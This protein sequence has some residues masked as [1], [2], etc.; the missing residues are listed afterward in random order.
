MIQIAAATSRWPATTS[1]PAPCTASR[2]T[3]ETDEKD[4]RQW[5]DDHNVPAFLRLGDGH[6]LAVYAK[7]GPESTIYTPPFH[8][9]R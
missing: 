7:H 2:C 3:R 8:Q 1:P 4:R 5:Y 6:L 9:T